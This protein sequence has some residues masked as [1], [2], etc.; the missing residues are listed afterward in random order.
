MIDS[1]IYEDSGDSMDFKK[2]KKRMQ[3]KESAV[4]SR[5]KKKVYYE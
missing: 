5:M 1:Y 4:R 2:V 3:N